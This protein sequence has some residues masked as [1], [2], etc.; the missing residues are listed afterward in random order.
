M[1]TRLGGLAGP[2][3]GE[4]TERARRLNEEKIA[5]SISDDRRIYRITV[6]NATA[7]TLVRHDL[8]EELIPTVQ[9]LG[10]NNRVAVLS[11]APGQAVLRNV[12]AAVSCQTVVIFERLTRERR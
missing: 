2:A 11:V 9:A 5:R 1:P 6:T 7:G 4:V 12:G 8:R 3:L 10:L